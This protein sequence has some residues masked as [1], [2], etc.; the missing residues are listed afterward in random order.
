[1]HTPVCLV[2]A[3]LLL[4]ASVIVTACSV[5]DRV[6]QTEFQPVSDNEFVFLARASIANEPGVD[7]AAERERLEWISGDLARNGMCPH[8]WFLVERKPLQRGREALLG[9]P[10]N[11]IQY[12]GHCAAAPAAKAPTQ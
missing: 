3:A 4:L 1:M 6:D 12:R 11:E 9:Y 8:G 2:R 7:T 5:V 10:V